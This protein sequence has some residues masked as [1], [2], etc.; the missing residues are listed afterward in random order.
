MM[1]AKMYLFMPLKSKPT[2]GE[3]ACK[4]VRHLNT[5][6]LTTVA[7]CALLTLQDLVVHQSE[8]ATE[9]EDMEVVVMSVVMTVAEVMTA[10]TT[11]TTEMIVVEDMNDAM[12]VVMTAEVEVE[13]EVIVTTVANLGTSAV[14]APLAEIGDPTAEVAMAVAEV[15]ATTAGNLVISVVS[16]LKAEVGIVVVTAIVMTVVGAVKGAAKGMIHTEN[17]ALPIS[18]PMLVSIATPH[19]LNW[20]LLVS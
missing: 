1:E 7:N 15:I 4:K 3:P 17:E 2:A 16:A 13:A 9:V 11:A 19:P 5:T 6:S 18:R 14:N 10:V 12:I 20:Q 8:A